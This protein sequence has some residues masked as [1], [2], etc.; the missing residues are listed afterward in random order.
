MS[1]IRN[2]AIHNVIYLTFF[3]LQGAGCPAVGQVPAPGDPGEGRRLRWRRRGGRRHLHL[4]QLPRPQELGDLLRV[5]ER[6]R[7]GQSG[8]LHA[9]G[10]V[11]GNSSSLDV[12]TSVPDTDPPDPHVFGPPGSGSVS[13]RYGSE[14]GSFYD[15]AKI[16]R[17]L[18]VFLSFKMMYKYLKKVIYRKTFFK[19]LVFVGI[20]KVSDEN[21]R[22]RIRIGIRIH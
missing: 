15:Q 10:E 11:I 5:Q 17:H 6:G 9:S 16:V 8:C 18:F 3:S 7:V 4:L 19:K 22:I 21:R 14:S 2:T 20:F 1:C 12:F 13:Q